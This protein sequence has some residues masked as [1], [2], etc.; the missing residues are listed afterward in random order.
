M[1]GYLGIGGRIGSP[2]EKALGANSSVMGGPDG[3]RVGALDAGAAR[4]GPDG[5]PLMGPGACVGGRAMFAV[6]GGG[7]VKT[8]SPCGGFV[9]LG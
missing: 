8:L 2:G 5:F 7:P 6:G 9:R 3:W 1:E 4:T